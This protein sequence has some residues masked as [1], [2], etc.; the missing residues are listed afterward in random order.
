MSGAVF[1]VSCD[2]AV[3]LSRNVESVQCPT[4]HR[5][6]YGNAHQ[7]RTIRNAN[8]S[9]SHGNLFVDDLFLGRFKK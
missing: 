5:V 4:V 8:F 2:A 7:K 3:R 9:I 6:I 1:A